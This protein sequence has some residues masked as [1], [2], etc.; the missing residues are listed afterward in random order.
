MATW[1]T[2]NRGCEGLSKH[3]PAGKVLSK[4]TMLRGDADAFAWSALDRDSACIARVSTRQVLNLGH[5][6]LGHLARIVL[7]RRCWR[8]AR[9][10]NND[11][12]ER[13]EESS[14]HYR[15]LRITVRLSGG[16]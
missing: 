14:Y 2:D 7:T 12:Y 1:A 9:T 6:F 4:P 10:A 8:E 16:A 11:G 3:D 5:G 15:L 13:N